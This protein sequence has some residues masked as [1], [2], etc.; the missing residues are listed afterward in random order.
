MASVKEVPVLPVS[1]G[2]CWCV[3]LS[4]VDESDS[5]LIAIL[6]G[7]ERQLSQAHA[8]FEI[9]AMPEKMV[10]LTALYGLTERL[11]L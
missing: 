4:D 2:E 5:V 3:D 6:C 10:N 1:S 8:S 7:F 11:G 9:V